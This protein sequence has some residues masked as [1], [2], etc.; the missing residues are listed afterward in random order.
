MPIEREL[1]PLL[2]PSDVWR[3]IR[4][5]LWYR[6]ELCFYSCPAKDVID[7]PR[8]QFL[9]RDY[10]EDLQYYERSEREQM[11]PVDYRRESQ[12]RMA[13][14]Y[15]LYTLIE[16]GKLLFYGW[17]VDRQGRSEDPLMGQV[18][19]PPSDASVVFDCYVHP[20]ARGR[21]LY[22]QALCQMLRDAHWLAQAGQIC[23]GVF[24]DNLVSRHVIDKCRFCYIGSM[25]KERRLWVVK[26]YAI[27]AAPEF[28]T[29]LLVCRPNGLF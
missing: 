13:Q 3:S 20:A 16:D 11:T 24:A 6:L 18:F 5:R 14:N 26:R 4:N 23:I 12:R 10:F 28:R 25:I 19:F 27:A 8:M 15:H 7:L 1:Q 22:S 9:R 29:A 2:T 17:L 21:G